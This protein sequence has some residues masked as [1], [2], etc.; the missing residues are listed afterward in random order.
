MIDDPL[1]SYS[2][3]SIEY[4]NDCFKIQEDVAI[5]LSKLSCVPWTLAVA[6]SDTALNR[7]K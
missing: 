7:K 1:Q 6:Y 4:K 2:G 3:V 5:M